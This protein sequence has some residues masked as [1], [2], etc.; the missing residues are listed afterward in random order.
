MLQIKNLNFTIF[1]QPK[2]WHRFWEGMLQIGWEIEWKPNQES[3]ETTKLQVNPKTLSV[4]R[5]VQPNAKLQVNPKTLSI[6]RHVR[7]NAKLLDMAIREEFLYFLVEF[8]TIMILEFLQS[9]FRNFGDIPKSVPIRE[10]EENPHVW[11]NIEWSNM[12]N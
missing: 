11:P 9:L 6:K 5:H 4:R 1:S 7:P 10:I 2:N 8:Q 12:A 3:I